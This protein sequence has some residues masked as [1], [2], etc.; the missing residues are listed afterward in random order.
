[1]ENLRFSTVL[2]P[3]PVRCLN[4][5]NLLKDNDNEPHQIELETKI[6]KLMKD[7]INFYSKLQSFTKYPNKKTKKNVRIK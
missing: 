7:E 2:H 5:Y 3:K 1:M 4:T 6:R